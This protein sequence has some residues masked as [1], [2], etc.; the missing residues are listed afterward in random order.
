MVLGLYKHPNC[1]SGR[2]PHQ[3]GEKVVV[4]EKEENKPKACYRL[5]NDSDPIC[6]GGE[7]SSHARLITAIRLHQ[8]AHDHSQRPCLPRETREMSRSWKMETQVSPLYLSRTISITMGAQHS[9]LSLGYSSK[10]HCR[11]CVKMSE[12]LHFDR[13]FRIL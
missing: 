7:N 2:V 6:V 11:I 4:D 5:D 10:G 8:A 12:Q 13:S 1:T 9:F 3:H